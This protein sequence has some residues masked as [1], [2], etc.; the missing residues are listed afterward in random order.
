M[1][2]TSRTIG[3]EGSRI[4]L[5]ALALA[6]VVMTG[7][8]LALVLLPDFAGNYVVRGIGYL[9]AIFFG[10]CTAIAVS[11]A[12]RAQ[13]IVVTISPQ[14]VRDTRV[15]A[16]VIPWRAVRR[17][18]T[19]EFRNQKVMV[20]VVDPAVE[21]SMTLTRMARWTRKANAALG[22][23]GLCIAATGIKISHDTLFATA[24]AYARQHGGNA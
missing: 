21:Q 13:E 19:W 7:A 8:S 12:L 11:R 17:I 15:A 20:V 3:I 10:A 4:K 14:G 23:D 24:T 5:L 1:I 22:A 2:D 6:G 9:G 18:F 16:E